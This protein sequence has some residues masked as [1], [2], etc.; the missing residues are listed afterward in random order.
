MQKKLIALAAVLAA[1]YGLVGGSAADQ[2]AESITARAAVID[3]AVQA[4]TN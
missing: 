2:A 4:A 3:S 1:V